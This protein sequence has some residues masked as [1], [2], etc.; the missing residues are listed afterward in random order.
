M[1]SG[2]YKIENKI[3]NKYYIGSSKNIEHRF[4]MHKSALK[5][6]RHKNILLQRAI[7]KYG[8][9]NFDFSILEIVKEY[10]LIL[11]EQ[12]YIDMANKQFLY[13]ISLLA[14]RPMT[15]LKHSLESRE[16]IS[17]SRIGNKYALGTTH[18]KPTDY[19]NKLS[20]KM[21]GKQPTQ[22]TIAASIVNR[23]P[24]VQMDMHNN[25]IKYFSSMID[26]ELETGAHHIGQVCNGN[27]K[28]SGGFKWKY[29]T[30]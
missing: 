6:N 5:H 27:R 15:G 25:I 23:K 22:A 30:I 16:K 21:K 18:K 28:S 17:K 24:V 4:I 2:I 29:N 13:N 26:A 12:Y 11:K 8:I 7:N 14:G 1:T 3:N 19:R 10:E 9:D 20:E